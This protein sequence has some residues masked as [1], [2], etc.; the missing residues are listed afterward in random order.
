MKANINNDEVKPKFHVVK[1]AAK[2]QV[3]K[4]TDDPT[5]EGKDENKVGRVQR[6]IGRVEKAPR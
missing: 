6:K 5:L 3:R 1:G 2:P 4:L